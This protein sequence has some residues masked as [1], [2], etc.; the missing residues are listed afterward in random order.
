MSFGFKKDTSTLVPIATQSPSSAV[1]KALD[2]LIKSGHK[3]SFEIVEAGEFK[4]LIVKD[5][6]P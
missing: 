5:A 1:Q 2:A 6:A 4:K 3:F